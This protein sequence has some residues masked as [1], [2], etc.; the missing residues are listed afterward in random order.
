MLS[1]YVKVEND[2]EISGK[3]RDEEIIQTILAKSQEI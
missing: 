2:F 3:L 1:E